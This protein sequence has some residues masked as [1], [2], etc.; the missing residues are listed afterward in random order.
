MFNENNIDIKM[1]EVKQIF[2]PYDTDKDGA[3]NFLEFKSSAL[4][5]EGDN[6]LVEIMKEIRYRQN[7]K[8]EDDPS[9]PTFIPMSF[10]KMIKFFCYKTNRKHILEILKKKTI[11]LEEEKKKLENYN[12]NRPVKKKMNLRE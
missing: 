2:Q 5:P 9:R 4:S 7:K 12:L 10:A 8:D 11:G 6:K 3:L 1:S